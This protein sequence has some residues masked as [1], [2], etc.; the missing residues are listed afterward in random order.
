[1]QI[2]GLVLSGYSVIESSFHPTY[3]S[4]T[5]SCGMPTILLKVNTVLYVNIMKVY[6]GLKA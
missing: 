4:P 6:E 5:T 2:S 1:M 3:P